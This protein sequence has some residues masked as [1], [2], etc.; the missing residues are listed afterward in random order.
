MEL[1]VADLLRMGASY[2][3][4]KISEFEMMSLRLSLRE[5]GAV[6]PV[7][8][9]SRSRLIVGGH[10]RVRAAELEGMV[11]LPVV[12]VDLD[13]VQERSLNLAL[14][15]IHGEWDFDLLGPMLEQ[16]RSGSADMS[17]TGFGES[18]I[19]AIL[20]KLAATSRG[21]TEPDDVPSVPVE[22]VSC[23]G[24]LIALGQHRLMVGDSTNGPMVDRLF[25][26]ILADCMWTDPPYGVDYEGKTKRK[27]TIENDGSS[28]L[29][30][31]L[32]G[33]F[34]QAD[35]HLS[36]G[37]P[38]Y[39]SHPA[40]ALS[41]V[42]AGSFLGV[43][44]SWRQTLVWVKDVFVMGHSDYHYKHEPI[45]YGYK[46]ATGQGRLGRGG[47]GWHGDNK[48]DSVFDIPR[49]R[50]SRE[51]PTMKPVELIE[52]CLSNSTE[53]GQTVYDPFLG[54]GSTLIACEKMGRRCVGLEIDR[55]YADVII[56]R[57][58]NF[59]GKVATRVEAP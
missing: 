59:T 22:A 31:L 52:A 21:L 19:D 1:S 54:S 17:V 24:D 10:Q 9:N 48:Q 43:G 32:L 20:A 50:A 4:R 40:G 16:L 58:Q 35:L 3:P 2:N 11:S 27:L 45:L 57:W 37:G 34:E 15:R 25:G 6:Q 42:F 49:P 55:A 30:M 28:G 44:W 51:H 29:G 36:P 33:A 56:E 47:P 5:F 7:V 39:V 13:D 26:D 53:A 38:V 46:P 12:Y 23:H 14:N 41:G 8:V 18:E